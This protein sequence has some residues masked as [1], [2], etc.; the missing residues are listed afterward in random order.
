MGLKVMQGSSGVKSIRGQL[1][2]MPKVTKCGQCHFSL[3]AEKINNL[4]RIIIAY[5]VIGLIMP[6]CALV[7]AFKCTYC[8]KN[9]PNEAPTAKLW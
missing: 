2:E 1:N 7:Y 4:A 3:R 9:V 6:V 8:S 5:F